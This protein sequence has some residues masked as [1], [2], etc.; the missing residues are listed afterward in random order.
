[1]VSVIEKFNFKIPCVAPYKAAMPNLKSKWHVCVVW[2]RQFSASRDPHSITN[3][4]AGS[5]LWNWMFL[6]RTP[7]YDWYTLPKIAGPLLL[8]SGKT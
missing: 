4:I 6:Y 7:L 1:M 3:H 5:A 8:V 2:L